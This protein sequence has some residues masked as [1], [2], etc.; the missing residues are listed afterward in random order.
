MKL[1]CTRFLFSKIPYITT[2]TNKCKYKIQNRHILYSITFSSSSF[3]DE[4]I[5]RKRGED[6]GKGRKKREEEEKVG[7]LTKA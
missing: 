6:K 4:R 5:W 7:Y 2:I 3:E 1:E